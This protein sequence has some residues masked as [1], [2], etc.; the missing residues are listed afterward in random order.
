[1]VEESPHSRA[2]T[3]SRR[4][5][6]LGDILLVA[7]ATLCLWGILPRIGPEVANLPGFGYNCDAAPSA[8]V[9]VVDALRQ[10]CALPV[11]LENHAPPYKRQFFGSGWADLDHDG[12]DTRAEVLRR[13]FEAPRFS[14]RDPCRLVAGRFHDPYTGTIR[15]FAKPPGK[16]VQI[17]HVVALGDAWVSGA[18]T[19]SLT[20]RQRYANDPGVLLATDGKANEDKEKSAADSWMPPNKAYHCAY[21]RQQINVKYRWELSVTEPEKQALL[22]ALSRC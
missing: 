1:M 13:D 11:R 3:L 19:W 14:S 6:S 5:A 22:Q 10:L 4:N 18:F 8:T 7:F 20:Q 16:S 9:D 12:C 17:D 2:T 15:S 21:A